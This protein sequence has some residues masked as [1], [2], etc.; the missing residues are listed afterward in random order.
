MM[1]HRPLGAPT[2]ALAAALLVPACGGDNP[3]GLPDVFRSAIRVTVAP[4][5]VPAVQ[6]PI[7]GSVSA[8]YAVT[9]TELAGLG[10]EVV[11]VSSTI[12]DPQTGFQV[13]V[14]YF[15][16]DDLVVFVGSSRIDPG[17][18]LEVPKT[19]NYALP[20]FRAQADLVVTVQFRDDRGNTIN[21][22]LLVKVV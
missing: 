18:T 3:A 4:N 15:D 13:T 22:S 12:F 6:S 9:I 11:F 8:G 1:S 19:M 21:S 17:G 16:S 10:G 20:D 2:L 5:P 7:T 14:N